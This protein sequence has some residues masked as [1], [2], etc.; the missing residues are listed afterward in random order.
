MT[1]IMTA[2]S[3]DHQFQFE[4]LEDFNDNKGDDGAE[5]SFSCDDANYTAMVS[6]CD[7]IG[8]EHDL[9][10]L[11]HLND[12]DNSDTSADQIMKIQI[13]LDNE[14]ISFDSACNVEMELYCVND[15]NAW[16]LQKAR[17][18]G[19]VINDNLLNHIDPDDFWNYC[20]TELGYASYEYDNE[21]FVYLI[22]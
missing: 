1:I 15:I 7:F 11:K 12:L 14:S 22:Q 8:D 18:A 21:T 10:H 19:N 16:A 2:T 17:D 3:E 20:E 6:V 9:S 4:T 13:A 5:Y